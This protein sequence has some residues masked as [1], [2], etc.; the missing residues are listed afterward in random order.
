MYPAIFLFCEMVIGCFQTDDRYLYVR[1]RQDI[2]W[3]R[4]F[5]KMIGRTRY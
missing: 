5:G 2:Y 1:D 4:K 3:V